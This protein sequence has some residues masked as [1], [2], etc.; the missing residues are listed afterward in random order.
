M[1]TQTML[2]MLTASIAAIGIAIDMRRLKIHRAGLSPPEWAIACIFLNVL[3]VLPYL[4]ERRRIWKKLIDAAWQFVGDDA[5][6]PD[7]RRARLDALRDCGVIGE[8][9]YRACLKNPQAKSCN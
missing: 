8:P 7:A 9:V 4:I 3:A 1:K 6:S 5:Y 2:W